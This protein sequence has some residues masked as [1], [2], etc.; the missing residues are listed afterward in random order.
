MQQSTAWKSSFHESPNMSSEHVTST[1]LTHPEGSCNK[2]V[3]Y[4]ISP[5]TTHTF[6]TR[7]GAQQ[8]PGHPYTP[9]NLTLAVLSSPEDARQQYCKTPPP[10]KDLCKAVHHAARNAM[11]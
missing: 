9:H 5:T 7:N 6:S 11:H 4:N 1:V 3:L 2:A 10:T 8:Q